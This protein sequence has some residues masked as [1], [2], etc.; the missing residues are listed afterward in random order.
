MTRVSQILR[1]E[2]DKL[3]LARENKELTKVELFEVQCEVSKKLIEILDEDYLFTE[4]Y[5]K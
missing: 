3:D 2:A 1:I 4:K 5:E